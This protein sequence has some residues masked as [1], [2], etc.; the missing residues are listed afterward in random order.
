[1]AEQQTFA[2]RWRDFRVSKTALFFSCVGSVVVALIIGFNWGGWVTGGT[3][4]RMAEQAMQEGR[5]KLAASI[6]V[7]RFMDGKDARAQLAMLKDKSVWE[8]DDFIAD[9]GWVTFAGVESSIPGAADRC[10]QRLAEMKRPEQQ[11][12]TTAVQ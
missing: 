8:R 11:A 5:A 3:A 7:D 2:E 9:G 1:M 6:C 12:G 4:K 10:A